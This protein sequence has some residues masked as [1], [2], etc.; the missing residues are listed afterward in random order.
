VAS[1]LLSRPRARLRRVSHPN[2]GLPPL[3]T[4]AAFP[5]AAERL[6]AA[7]AP[8]GVRA[9]EAFTA[10]DATIRDRY[11]EAGLRA[12]LR[13]TEIWAE[14]IARCV[15][16]GSAE[17]MRT[18]AEQLVPL[19]RRRRVSMD[20]LV[21]FAEALRGSIRSVLGPAELAIADT[22]LDEANAVFRWHRRLAGD[23]RKR[24]RLLQLI[25]K[26]A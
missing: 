24:N 18:W 5:A 20:D 6:R 7:I 12:M 1:Q 11:G 13:D 9:M 21:R 23:A 3:D 14:Q 26:G 2:L 10:S 19:Y 4:H 25:Y 17:P 15:A 16:S 22:A 8:I